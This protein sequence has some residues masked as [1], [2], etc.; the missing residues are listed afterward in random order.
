M[1]WH[2]IVIG[3]GAAGCAVAYRLSLAGHLPPV[4]LLEA[5]PDDT[6]PRIKVP[7]AFPQLLGSRFDWGYQTAPQRGAESRQ[8]RW[9]RGRVLGGSTSI[10]AMVYQR[11]HRAV[12][13]EWAALG[14]P[15]WD[16]ETMLPNFKRN[17]NQMRGNNKYHATGGPL[18]VEDQRDPNP[19]TIAMIEA[20]NNLGYPLNSDFNGAVQEGFG[21]FQVTQRKGIRHSAADAYLRPSQQNNLAWKTDAHVTRLLFDQDRCVGV[22]YMQLGELHQVRAKVEVLVC[23]GT[24]NSP[25]LLMLSGIGPADHLREHGIDVI[26]DVPGVGQNLQ[27]HPAMMLSWATKHA[28]SKLRRSRRVN[29]LAYKMIKRGKLASPLAEGGGFVT[30]GDEAICPDAQF[31]FIPDYFIGHGDHSPGGAGITIAASAVRPRSRGAITLESSDPFAPPR[32]DPRYFDDPRDLETLVEAAKLAREF[33]RQKPLSKYIQTEYMPGA[34]ITEDDHLAEVIRA[35]AQ[36]MYHPAGTCKMGP[37]SDPMAVV[38]ANLHVRG[39]Q[40]LRVIDASIMPTI[41]NANINAATQAIAEKGA[42]LVRRKT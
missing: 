26:A 12:Y 41:A 2:Y 37:E 36:T 10:N 34:S 30:L 42:D 38:D 11:G 15:G 32:I 24:I 1:D 3:A 13:D 8:M 35:H 7:S 33:T 21:L 23:A 19:M 18:N 14:N 9:P 31:H 20:A 6:D 5:G 28:S 17:Q 25:Q 22:E 27:D 29:K 40:G 4:L 39:V 16:Y